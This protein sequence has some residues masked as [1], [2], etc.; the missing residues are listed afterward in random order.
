MMC[1]CSPSRRRLRWLQAQ[2]SARRS[3]AAHSQRLGGVAALATRQ[4]QLLSEEDVAGFHELGYITLPGLLSSE[5]CAALAVDFEA[6]GP[7][8]ERFVVG[9]DPRLWQPSHLPVLG[10]LS[11]FEPVVE[12]VKQ[13]MVAHGERGGESTFSFHHQHADIFLPGA[14]GSPWHQDY[15]QRPQVDRDLLMVHCFC[16]CVRACVRAVLPALPT[17]APAERVEDL[18]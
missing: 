8:G 2:L 15:V 17:S 16:A 12:R 14:P 18:A 6:F 11:S 1:S 4:Q 7:E 3:A 9:G 13:L 10:A 5:H